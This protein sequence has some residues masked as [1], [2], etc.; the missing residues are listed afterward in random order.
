MNAPTNDAGFEALLDYLQRSRGFDFT[1]YK[2]GGLMRRM[3]KRMQQ[4]GVESFSAYLDYLE[5]HPEEFAQ[6]FNSLLINV[7]AF[8]RDPPAWEMLAHD[9]V[10]QILKHKK[11][12][13]PI[14]VWSA[15][16]A[17]GEEAYS[18]AMALAEHLG[19]AALC[20]RVKI[21]ATDVD[22]DA[23]NKAR[24]AVY[25]PQDVA[26][27]PPTHLEK[28]FE[29]VN[30]G[31]SFNKHLR[32]SVIFGRHDLIQDAPISRVDLLVCRN[33]L[34]YFHAEA[35]SRILARF[36]FA[37]NDAGFLFLGKAEMLLTHSNLFTPVSLRRRI[38]AKVPKIN[39]RDRLLILAQTGREESLENNLINHVRLREAAFETD[40]QAHCVVDHHGILLLANEAARKLF[41]L[42]VKD[43]GRPFQDL[44]VS[45]R[46]LEL[47]SSIEQAYSQRSPVVIKE[48]R[49]VDREGVTRFLD[50]QILPLFD[51]SGAPLGVKIIF[52]DV[53]RYRKLQDD[54]QQSHQE[55]ET[56]YEELQTSNEELQSTNEELETTNE[57]LQST[58]EELETMNEE[59]QSSNEELRT[60]N[61]ELQLRTDE[62][63]QVNAFLESILT[64]LR[65]AVAVLDRNLTVQA[66][67][68]R[69]EDLW[70]LRTDEVQGKNFLNLDIGLPVDQL[71]QPIRACIAGESPHQEVSVPAM[72]RR[73]RKIDCQVTCSPLEGSSQDVR[74][75]ILLMEEKAPSADGEPSP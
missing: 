10:P 14:R 9:I 53:T 74:G 1:A 71:R 24:L 3:Q 17:S 42:A 29:P 75:V 73:G 23:L 56:A 59:L 45:Y 68:H 50:V 58:N 31:Y 44:E 19:T 7:T 6:L 63:N 64:G 26:G 40:P 4:V 20:E 46:P 61:D 21:Y 55:L 67:N 12:A 49:W 35:Q 57:E 66:W 41:N 22:E 37:L 69:A 34:M 33:V 70:G 72:T 18:L 47:R 28:Y 13:E 2:S 15:G 11:A 16:C 62:L 25:R 5:V 43:L 8:F 30:N 27:V 51:L 54:L 52:S 60:I 39:L 36:H 48:A 32:R 38:F 65:A